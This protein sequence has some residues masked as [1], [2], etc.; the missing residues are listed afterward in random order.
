MA[1]EPHP[2]VS[3]REQ[4]F[5]EDLLKL[6]KHLFQEVGYDSDVGF[7]C[8]QDADPPKF[9]LQ[10]EIVRMPGLIHGELGQDKG[11]WDGEAAKW[12]LKPEDRLRSFRGNGRSFVAITLL[13][14]APFKPLIGLDMS[15]GKRCRFEVNVL[16]AGAEVSMANSTT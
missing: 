4:A 14:G 8:R 10:A 7:L 6:L 13:P 15:T 11:H 2:K 1:S 12:N 5:M 3:R 16:D 9:L